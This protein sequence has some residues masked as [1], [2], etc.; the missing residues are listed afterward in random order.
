[1][2]FDIFTVLVASCSVVFVLGIVILLF[3]SRNR[4]AGWLAWWSI[5]FLILG[6][7]NILVM[8]RPAL[9]DVW[10]AAVGSSLLVLGFGLIW[11]SLRIFEGRRPVMW[12]IA[13]GVAIWLVLFFIPPIRASVAI[14]VIISSI[15]IAASLALGAYEIWRGRTEKLPSRI[16]MIIVLLVLAGIFAVRVPLAFILPYPMGGLPVDPLWVAGFNGAI[17][18]SAIISSVFLV[19]L[20]L[21]RAERN[22]RTLAETDPLTGLLNRRALFDVFGVLKVPHDTAVIMFDL[23][24]FKFINDRY[25]HAVGDEL[26]CRFT[27]VCQ[28]NIRQVDI[29]ARLGGEEFAI[30]LPVTNAKY[31]LTIAERIRV[32]FADVMVDTIDGPVGCTVSAGIEVTTADDLRYI[33]GLLERADTELYRAKRS[34]RNRVCL[35][36]DGVAA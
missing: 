5:A 28:E 7:G 30:I 24:R 35:S 36:G 33:E 9:F 11:Q 17:F 14:R 3:W 22:Q 8:S 32:S 18:V 15:P 2:Q 6:F 25:G 10:S 26:L 29:A 27:K 34:G 19:S 12:P 31:A 4:K 21:E 13:V 16:P 20:T 1:M 23:D